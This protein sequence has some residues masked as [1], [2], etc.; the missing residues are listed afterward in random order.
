MPTTDADR[1]SVMERLKSYSRRLDEV[2]KLVM[3]NSFLS[4]AE[5]AKA[6]QLYRAVKEDL[7]RDYEAGSTR[8][9]EAELT[10]AEKAYL[11]PAVHKAYCHLHSG[12]NTNPVS[13]KWG[14]QLY[15]ARSDINLMLAQLTE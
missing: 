13:S 15:T 1:T 7:K 10:S 14:D 4:P 2:M 5:K 3:G 12:W 9:G 8:R 6:Q 11:H